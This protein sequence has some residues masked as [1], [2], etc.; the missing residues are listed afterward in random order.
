M[1]FYLF[2]K[3]FKLKDKNFSISYKQI[4]YPFSKIDI[5]ELTV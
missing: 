4:K 3:K 2:E 5:K 1:T